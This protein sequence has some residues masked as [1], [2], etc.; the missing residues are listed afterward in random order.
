MIA[1]KYWLTL[2]YFA[3]NNLGK[4]VIAELLEHNIHSLS[5]DKFILKFAFLS[6]PKFFFNKSNNRKAY[7]NKSIDL[8]CIADIWFH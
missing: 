2:Y 7:I 4:I 6:T 8:Q 3:L 5:K 1:I